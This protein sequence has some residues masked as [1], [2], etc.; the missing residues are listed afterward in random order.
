M[1]IYKPLYYTISS[2][3]TQGSIYWV[4]T[5]L[6]VRGLD[7]VKSLSQIWHLE[8]SNKTIREIQNQQRVRLTDSPFSIIAILGS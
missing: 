3:I 5:W 2:R 4:K 7:R 8:R 6:S 1:N